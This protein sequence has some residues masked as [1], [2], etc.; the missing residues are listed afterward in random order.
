MD[1]RRLP[2]EAGSRQGQLRE[3]RLDT[4]CFGNGLEVHLPVGVREH[5][6]SGMY[7]G[8]SGL[9]G[10]R[11]AGVATSSVEGDVHPDNASCTGGKVLQP[12][13]EEQDSAGNTLGRWRRWPGLAHGRVLQDGRGILRGLAGNSSTFAYI[14]WLMHTTVMYSELKKLTEVPTSLGRCLQ[15]YKS[16]SMH[17]CASTSC[18]EW[19]EGDLFILTVLTHLSMKAVLT[20]ADKSIDA[21]LASTVVLTWVACA[22]INVCRKKASPTERLM[23]ATHIRM[24]SNKDSRVYLRI[25]VRLVWLHICNT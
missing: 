22:L 10:V 4:G 7:Y 16:R 19:G 3:D 14:F 17:T 18:R 8:W 5:Y 24:P 20:G 23:A 2:G 12:S 21:V 1:Q 11:A 25:L 15:R 9:F 6:I 13:D